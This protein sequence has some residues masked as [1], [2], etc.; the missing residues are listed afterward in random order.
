MTIGVYGIYDTNTEK[1]LYVGQSINI[2]NRF[3]EHVK[4]LKNKSHRNKDFVLWY[5]LNGYSSMRL[6]ILE[7]CINNDYVKNKTEIKW[8]NMLNPLFFGK[9][10]SVNE[11]WKMSEE[12]KGKISNSLKSNFD[13]II[14]RCLYCG[15]DMELIKSSKRKFCSSKCTNK[16][17]VE[18]YKPIDTYEKMKKLYIYEDKSYREIAKMYNTDRMR[19]SRS[20][21][22]YNLNNY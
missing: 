5:E 11:K 4:K 1:C 14:K 20:I 18:N 3:K 13:Y 8:F 15:V 21:H 9:K 2:E 17:K 19:I 6:D 22:F 12:T 10:P 7:E 16:H